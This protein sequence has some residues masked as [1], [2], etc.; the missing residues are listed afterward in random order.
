MTED[1]DLLR[2]AQRYLESARLLREAGDRDSAVSRTYYAAFYVAEVLLD[3]LGLSFSSHR[4]VISAFGQEFA[5]TGRLDARFHRLL[6]SAFEKRQRADYL[7]DAGL[8]D[9]EVAQLIADAESFASA[10]RAWLQG[11]DSKRASDR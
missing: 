5:K 7:A 1:P 4:A 2:K 8:D 11:P 10:A 6:I 3:A 9:M